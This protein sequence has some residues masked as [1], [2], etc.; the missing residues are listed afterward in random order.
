MRDGW[1]VLHDEDALFADGLTI[2]HGDCRFPKH[3]FRS[4]RV[5]LDGCAQRAHLVIGGAVYF[6][7][8]GNVGH[9]HVRFARMVETFVPGA[10]GVEH[11]DVNIRL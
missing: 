6:A 2:P 7:D 5:V 11:D 4:R 1:P 3:H 8:H 10:V 9:A